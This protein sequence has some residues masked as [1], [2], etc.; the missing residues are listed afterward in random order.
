MHAAQ[1]HK[2]LKYLIGVHIRRKQQVSPGGNCRSQT[3]ALVINYLTAAGKMYKYKLR[4][5]TVDISFCLRHSRLKGYALMRSKI[6]NPI[7]Q[8]AA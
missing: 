3:I 5:I 8:T 6:E 4:R 1:L 7:L 2:L